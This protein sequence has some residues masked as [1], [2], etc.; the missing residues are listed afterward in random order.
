MNKNYYRKNNNRA[1][2]KP[3]IEE[4]I[5]ETKREPLCQVEVTHPSLRIRKEPS[6]NAEQVGLITDKGRYNIYAKNNNWGQLEDN[7]WI[8][9][10]FTTKI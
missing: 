3:Q 4:I 7:T 2:E 9:L 5:I 1:V 8:C 10:D 6:V